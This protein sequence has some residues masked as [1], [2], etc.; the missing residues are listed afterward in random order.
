MMIHQTVMMKKCLTWNKKIQNTKNVGGGWENGWK[1]YFNTLCNSCRYP[2]CK[3]R[4]LPVSLVRV[5]PNG[6]YQ[7]FEITIVQEILKNLNIEELLF[8][9]ITVT[10]EYI[11]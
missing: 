7:G 5:S 2:S 3:Y 6:A 11:V 9:I 1:E 10:H 8:D 4:V